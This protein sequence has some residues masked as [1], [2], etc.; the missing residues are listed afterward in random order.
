MTAHTPPLL[1]HLL[2]WELVLL[3]RQQMIVI[4][5]VTAAV[6][7]GLFYLLRN[8][9]SLDRVLVLMIY[10]DPVIMSYLFAGVLLLFE[11][12]ENTLAALAVSPLPM[13]QYLWSKGVALTLVATGTA[14]VMAWVGHGF[15]LQYVPFLIGMIGSSLQFAWVGCAMGARARDFSQFLLRSIGGMIVGAVP[16]LALFDVWDH[17]L[18]YLLP[19]Y[20]GVLLLQAAFEPITLG[21]WLYSLVYLGLGLVGAYRWS[22]QTL[23]TV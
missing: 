10:N 9:G 22:Q 6:Y 2:K 21:Q 7:L 1:P 12:N 19:T 3:H 14:L 20:P 13:R 8:L 11:K 18:V 15:R 4:S 16:F 23:Q 17:P 5:L